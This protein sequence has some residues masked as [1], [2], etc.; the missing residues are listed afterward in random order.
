MENGRLRGLALAVT[1]I[2]E[3]GYAFTVVANALSRVRLYAAQTVDPTTQPIPADPDSHAGQAAIEA[4]NRLNSAYGGVPGLLRDA[5]MNIQISGECL[6][7]Q[8]PAN[9]FASPPQPES[10]DIRS[11]H[12]IQVDS[13]GNF[14]LSPREDGDKSSQS[15]SGRMLLV[16]SSEN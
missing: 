12:E 15:R 10:W 1:Y 3:I 2:G 11:A 6:L 5:A 9:P 4:L 8:R 16:E 7:V 14:V 13:S